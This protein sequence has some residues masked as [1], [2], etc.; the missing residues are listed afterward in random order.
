[1]RKIITT[2]SMLVNTLVWAQAPC[3]ESKQVSTAGATIS[4]KGANANLG[5]V[6]GNLFDANQNSKWLDFSNDTW[7]QIKFASVNKKAI[8]KYTFTSANDSPERDPANWV[9]QGSNNGQTWVTL[10]TR[11][12]QIF[13]SRYATNTYTFVNNTAYE[14]YQ[15]NIQS[16]DQVGKLT[17]LAEVVLYETAS[18]TSGNT[19]A[20]SNAFAAEIKLKSF[21]IPSNSQQ[22]PVVN[23]TTSATISI[24]ALNSGH[25]IYTTIYGNNT[26]IFMGKDVVGR[27]DAMEHYKNAK[28]SVMRYPGGS[29][30]DNFFWDGNVP[31]NVKSGTAINPEGTYVNSPSRWQMN[32][33]DFM[34]LANTCGSTPIITVNYGYAKYGKSANPVSTA[35]GYAAAWVR[36]AKQKGYKI[37]YWE[38]G[39]ENF[40]AW[41]A[42]SVVEGVR[43]EGDVYGRDFRVFVDS[44]KA[45]DPSIKIGAVL[46]EE[47]AGPEYWDRK[48]LPEIQNHADFLIVHNYYYYTGGSPSAVPASDVFT[49]MQTVANDK[50]VIDQLVA[51]FTNKPAGYFPLALTEFNTSA[52]GS[53]LNEASYVNAVFTSYA[54]AEMA[55]NKYG[56]AT[57]W[58]MQEPYNTGNGG[59][60]GMI[61]RDDPN[62]SNHT[63]YPGFYP[64]YLFDKCFGDKYLPATTNNSN[65]RCYASQFTNT[66]DI[67]IVLINLSDKT[68]TASINLTNFSNGNLIY[69]YQ[70]NNVGN[71]VQSRKLSLNGQVNNQNA[72]GPTNYTSIL[73]FATSFTNNKLELPPYSVTFANI[74][75]TLTTK[76]DY[77]G[78]ELESENAKASPS[79]FVSNFE[80]SVPNWATQVNIYD[81]HGRFISGTKVS[82]NT[83]QI[84][85]NWKS[86]L[87]LIHF[88]GNGKFESLKVIK[89]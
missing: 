27:A 17:Q 74:A 57:K 76:L 61:S 46:K 16:S 56:L 29:A 58:M 23:Q 68:E 14:Y 70:L 39:N 5:E 1:M 86:G 2:V 15:F 7:F 82:E 38:V 44:M 63:P 72:G 48:A 88:E 24:D 41:E 42:G 18:C 80:L 22:A 71:N 45:A 6:V 12:G 51:Q 50:V 26:A 79:P 65:I 83:Y 60:H 9:L 25:S 62:C 75:N 35:A 78:E 32:F 64:Y 33:D 13:A 52:V 11:N 4:A 84:G 59:S 69:Y 87:Y 8:D 77:D 20:T 43:L 10:D 67:G 28:I 3:F 81:A 21:T 89:Q 66:K 31:T 54:L 37:K 55:K 85:G 73:P 34:Q 49:K 47:D 36:Y 30:S 40:G 53:G 19:G